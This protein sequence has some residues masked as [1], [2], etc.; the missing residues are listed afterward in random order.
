V[1]VS[2]RGRS[3]AELELRVRARRIVQEEIEFPVSGSNQEELARLRGDE[4][5]DRALGSRQRTSTLRK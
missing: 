5:L 1:I 4:L 2:V 3:Q